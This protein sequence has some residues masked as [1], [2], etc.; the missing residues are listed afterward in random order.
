MLQRAFD[1]RATKH[2]SSVM[3]GKGH[4]GLGRDGKCGDG[5]QAG[6]ENGGC[7]AMQHGGLLGQNAM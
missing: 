5:K 1:N 3:D 6:D 7:K 2:T 4:R